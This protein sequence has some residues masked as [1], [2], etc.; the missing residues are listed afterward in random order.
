MVERM[1]LFVYNQNPMFW[2][3]GSIS[4]FAL[5]INIISGVK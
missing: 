4:L 3:F 1:T 2:E 5:F